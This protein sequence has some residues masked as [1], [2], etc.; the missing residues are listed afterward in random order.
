MPCLHDVNRHRDR[1]LRPKIYL[2]NASYNEA[3]IY[4]ILVSDIYVIYVI[5]K[6]KVQVLPLNF[7]AIKSVNKLSIV[8]YSSENHQKMF[9]RLFFLFFVFNQCYAGTIHFHPNS[10]LSEKMEE[11]YKAY[12]STGAISYVANMT[13][14]CATGSAGYAQILSKPPKIDGVGRIHMGSNTKSM[15]ATLVGILLENNLIKGQTHGWKTKLMDIIPEYVNNTPYGKVTLDSLAAHFSGLHGNPTDAW[16]FDNPL[17]SLIE[18]R[19]NVTKAAFATKPVNPPNTK[20]LYSNW[21]YIILGHLVEISLNI[22]WEDALMKYLLKPLGLIDSTKDYPFYAP[23][24]KNANWGHMA[25]ADND[26][27]YPCDPNNPPHFVTDEIPQFKCDNPAYYA[28]CGAFSGSLLRT[29]NYYM[30]LIQCS[31]G[32]PTQDKIPLSKKGCLELME[33]Y[34]PTDP[35]DPLHSNRMYGH[36]WAMTNVTWKGQKVKML[37]HSG[38]NT[39]NLVTVEVYPSLGKIYWAGTNSAYSTDADMITKAIEDLKTYD[40]IKC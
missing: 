26:T 7:L 27:H 31:R 15:T 23:A 1:K 24:K 9:G 12:N 30:W 21:G 25:L 34:G 16:D 14:I 33:P 11:L 28:P 38:S 20:F 18:Q 37:T 2:C 19:A 35:D 13:H 6:H 32:M 36:G 5:H 17:E 4:V 3:V 8:I 22:S 29:A 39:M 40:F 10:K